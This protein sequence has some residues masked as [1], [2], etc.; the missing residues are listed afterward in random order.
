MPQSLILGTRGSDLALA[1][2]DMVAAAL[3]NAHPGLQITREIVR[4]VGDKRPDLKLSAF[5]QG[6]APVDK[7]IFTRELEAALAAGTI[8]IAVH[9]LKDVPTEVD[10]AYRIAATLPRAPVEDVLVTRTP[11]GL[12]ALPPGSTVAT[13]S[14]RRARQLRHLRPD[15]KTID[16]RGNVP[17]RLRKLAEATAEFQATMLARAGLERLGFSFQSD[18]LDPPDSLAES[19]APPG[20]LYSKTLD[21]LT[22]LPCAGQGAVAIE[23]RSDDPHAAAWLAPI[24]HPETF[25]RITAERAFLALLGAGCQT[26]VGTHTTI[27]TA[28]SEITL[29]A[30]VFDE[31]DPTKA[32]T[33]AVAT[34]PL[35]D[36]RAAAAEAF[37]LL[38]SAREA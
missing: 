32:P 26:P 38:K 5:N 28:R 8:D 17:T 4:T 6:D 25:A 19:A 23:I 29:H 11:G 31:D 33:E 30:R 21:P 13:S 36:P 20:V 27:D 10:P 2:A 7:G 35:A 14:V 24:N 18:T 37:R 12:A 9:S 16:I 22:F 34:S 1:Q 3:K 15:L